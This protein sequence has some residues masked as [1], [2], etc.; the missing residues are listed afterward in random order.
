MTIQFNTDKNIE[1]SAKLEAYVNTL[2]TDKL[3]RF[4]ENITRVEL[5]LSDENGDKKG[6]EDIRCTIE[7]RMANLQ[8]IAVSSNESTI[9]KA[10]NDSLAKLLSSLE[11]IKGK[12]QTH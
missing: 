10:I 9:E 2:I 6:P 5:H 1:G 8:P 12:Q 11:T 7:A 4:S 3:A